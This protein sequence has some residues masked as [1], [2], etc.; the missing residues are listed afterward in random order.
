[1]FIVDMNYVS[2]RP[3]RNRDTKLLT[4]RQGPGS[5]AMINEYLTETSFQIVGG[6]GTASTV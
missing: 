6:H 1:M 2:R 4:N 5:T 3:M